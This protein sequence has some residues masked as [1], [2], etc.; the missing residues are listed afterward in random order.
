MVTEKSQFLPEAGRMPGFASST[1]QAHA[2]MNIYVM[3]QAETS[4]NIR[5]PDDD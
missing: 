4:R 2:K 5:E 3:F 1:Q